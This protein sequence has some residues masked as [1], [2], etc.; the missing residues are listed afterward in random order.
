MARPRLKND[1]AD[2][3]ASVQTSRAPR[4]SLNL[5]THVALR[6]ILGLERWVNR[7]PR[8]CAQ[9]PC[10]MPRLEKESG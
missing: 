7:A 4:W 3:P 8:P 10:R 5:S 1:V 2:R 9:V 6:M